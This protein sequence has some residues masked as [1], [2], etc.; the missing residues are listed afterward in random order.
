MCVPCIAVDAVVFTTSV[1]VGSPSERQ[2]P[3][4]NVMKHAMNVNMF[5]GCFFGH[6]HDWSSQI[7]MPSDIKVLSLD[8]PT[9]R[10]ISPLSS[11]RAIHGLR[12]HWFI[13]IVA[14]MCATYPDDV[15]GART[16]K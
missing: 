4:V 11:A 5:I 8:N 13:C 7:E 15:S 1:G 2:K 6:L 16:W 12:Y 3:D 14:N 10:S 9:P